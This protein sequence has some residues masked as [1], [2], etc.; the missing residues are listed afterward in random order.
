MDWLQHFTILHLYHHWLRSTLFAI[1]FQSMILH[2]LIYNI[3]TRL[4][5]SPHTTEKEKQRERNDLLHIS[6]EPLLQE[7]AKQAH[8]VEQNSINIVCVCTCVTKC[9]PE[10]EY[11]IVQTEWLCLEM[12][13]I[14]LGWGEGPVRLSIHLSPPVYH[15]VTLTQKYNKTSEWHKLLEM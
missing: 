2:L 13:S 1:L 8:R 14:N 11:L 5:N 4:F 6:Y 15:S 12:V 10:R 3:T 7:E 9:L